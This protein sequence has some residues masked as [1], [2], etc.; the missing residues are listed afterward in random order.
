LQKILGARAAISIAVGLFITFSQ[1]H[2]AA[3]GLFA[4]AIFGIGFAITNV[5]ATV[6]AKE[7]YLSVESLPLT[8]IALAVGLFAALIPQTEPT[9]QALV[10][11]YLV[12]GWALI[13]GAME[14]Y[15]ANR[16]GFKTR[17]GK[18]GLISA[19]LG[20]GLGLLF[21]IAPLDIVSAVGFFGTYLV[22]SGVHLAI[23]ALTPQK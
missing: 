19:V 13:S 16:A 20:V 22:I 7:K 18:D 3:T 17:A 15:L 5:A 23:A 8:L 1:S 9:A 14:L 12:A 21:L 11:V 2:S 10:F 4:L 6:R